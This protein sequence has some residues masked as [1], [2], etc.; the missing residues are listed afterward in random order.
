MTLGTAL[1]ILHIVVTLMTAAM[2][3]TDFG[4]PIARASAAIY[5]LAQAWL[6]AYQS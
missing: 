2:L 6:E 5:L 3:L 4:H 1:T